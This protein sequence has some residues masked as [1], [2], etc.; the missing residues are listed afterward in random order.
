M[1]LANE[2]G[3]VKI[4]SSLTGFVRVVIST[5]TSYATASLT[6]TNDTKAIAVYGFPLFQTSE[7]LAALGR[8][9]LYHS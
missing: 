6:S 8:L 5:P 4:V 1:L 7:G 2:L 9:E 3:L